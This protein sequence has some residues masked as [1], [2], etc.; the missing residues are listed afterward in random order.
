M[1]EHRAAG[2]AAIQRQEAR[3][4]FFNPRIVTRAVK[5]AVNENRHHPHATAVRAFNGLWSEDFP[6]RHF[7]PW[8][9]RWRNTTT[10]RLSASP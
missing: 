2:A 1:D 8:H 10:L 9:G 4:K 7:Q 6:V 3:V 5:R